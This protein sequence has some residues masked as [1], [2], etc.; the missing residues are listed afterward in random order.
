M[1]KFFVY[2]DQIDNENKIIKIQGSDVNHI[3]NV[4]RLEINDDIEIG[5]RSNA[6]K[7]FISSI[8]DIT[9]KEVICKIKEELNNSSESELELTVFQG[10]PKF[11]KMEFIIQKCT[12]LGVTNFVPLE[13]KRCIVKIK[14]KDIDKKISR[15][16]KIAEV[17]AKQC[18]RN[19]IPN[20][21]NMSSLHEICNLINNYDMVIVAYEQEEKSELKELLTLYKKI[22]K[23]A[24]VIGPE[25]GFETDE[26]STLKEYGAKIVSLGNRILRTETASITLSSIIMYELGDIGGKKND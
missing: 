16:Q 10:I 1:K 3:V 21:M 12:E 7:T 23:I 6:P 26:I 14:Q 18:K 20:I 19:I 25:G 22:K 11:D 13:L 4:L 8:K 5:M 9:E 15:W 24:I 17:A 2:E